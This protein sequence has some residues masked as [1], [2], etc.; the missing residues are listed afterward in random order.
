MLL[1]T[2]AD[3]W[4]LAKPRITMMV[5]LTVA[6]AGFVGALGQVEVWP[7]VHAVVGAGLVAVGSS[8]ANQWWEWRS[9]AL[10]HRTCERPLAARR[11]PVGA[12]AAVCGTCTLVG[13]IW[14][15]V[16]TT[17]QAA[18]WAAATWIGYVLVYTPLK[19][20]TSLNTALGAVVGAMPILIGWTAVGAPVTVRCIAFAAMLFLWQFPHF[21]AIAWL[22]REDYRRGGLRMITVTDPTGREAGRQATL[23]SLALVPVSLVPA[24]YGYGWPA[25]VYAV[26]A[27]A[28]G[29]LLLAA[30]VAFQVGTSDRTARVLLRASLLY[31]PAMLFL[32]VWL[33]SA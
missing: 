26:A 33:V 24:L 22:Y 9:D 30:S 23:A 21:M 11:F 5:L 1:Q 13:L 16:A 28:C 29:T 14:L 7:L 17:W 20:I 31:L 6:V 18:F 32:M 10:M 4:V 2:A 3:L 25:M 8:I 15:V 12:A 19:R 27:A